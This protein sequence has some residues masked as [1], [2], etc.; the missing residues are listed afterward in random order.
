M[1]DLGRDGTLTWECEAV[2]LL[3]ERKHAKK[4]LVLMRQRLVDVTGRR[5]HGRGVG[6]QVGDVEYRF[7]YYIVAR[8]GN[9]WWGQYAMIVPREDLVPLLQL[10]RDEGTLLED[11]AIT[12]SRSG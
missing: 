10:A 11:F 7:G 5:F 2:T 8:N 4:V 1:K 6:S 12:K 9:W 3:E